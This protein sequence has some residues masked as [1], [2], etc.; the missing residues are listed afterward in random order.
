MSAASPMRRPN[1]NISR[2][3]E[4]AASKTSPVKP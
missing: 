2:V 1:G 3:M 4:T